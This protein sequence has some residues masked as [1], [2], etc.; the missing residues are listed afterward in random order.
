MMH[1]IHNGHVRVLSYLSVVQFSMSE[2]APASRE[3]LTILPQRFPFVKNFFS[4]FAKIFMNMRL[5]Q[6]IRGF[7]TVISKSDGFRMPSCIDS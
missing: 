4:Y 6:N 2:T 7:C 3:R 5:L 1:Y